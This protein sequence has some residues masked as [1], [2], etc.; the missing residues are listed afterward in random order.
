MKK[1]IKIYFDYFGYSEGS[2]IP[3]E[4]SGKA[5]VDIHHI[6]FGAKKVDNIENLMALTRKEHQKAHD[7]VYSR[8]YLQEKHNK[9][10]KRV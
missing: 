5:A 9:F 2:F 3:S 7:G 4:L 10:M 1:H 8:E 6:Q